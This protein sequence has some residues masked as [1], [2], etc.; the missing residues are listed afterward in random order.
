MDKVMDSIT[1]FFRH[2]D[3]HHF[4]QEFLQPNMEGSYGKI[5]LTSWG[6]RIVQFELTIAELEKGAIKCHPNQKKS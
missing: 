4:Q 1:D 2:E 3:I 6:T 5:D